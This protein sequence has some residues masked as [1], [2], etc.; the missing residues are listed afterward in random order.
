V[1]PKKKICSSRAGCQWPNACNPS[2]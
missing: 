2:Y 1:L